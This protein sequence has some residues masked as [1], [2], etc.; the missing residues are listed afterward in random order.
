MA[1]KVLSI[2]IG[3]DCTKVCEL[4]Y[5]KKY[6]NKGI[7]VY[8]SL[9][10][11]TP[12]GS[13][14]DGFIKDMNVFGEELKNR[15]KAAKIK[16]YRVVFTINSSRIANREIIIP[17]VKEKRIID[18][19]NTGASEYF[20]I[21][22]NEY[23]LSYQILEKSTA[24]SSKDNQKRLVKNEKKL[25]KKQAK[26]GK[27]ALK[28]RNKTQIIAENL[29][30]MNSI[31][32]LEA[33]RLD[34]DNTSGGRIGKEAKNQMRLTAY[35]AP[36]AMVRNYYSFAKQ[37]N[38]DI[39]AIDYYGNSS[40][41]AIKRQGRRGINVYV[42]MNEQDTIISILRDD[43]LILQRTVSFGL[44]KLIDII[45]DFGYGQGENE[46]DPIAL[47]R[48]HDMLTRDEGN[49]PLDETAVTESFTYEGSRQILT[50]NIRES[51]YTLVG[52]VTRMLDYYKSSH[53]QIDINTIYLTGALVDIKGA[54]T[55]FGSA[56]GLHHKIMYKLNSVKASKKAPSFRSNPSKFLTLIGAVIKPVDFIP[57]EFILKKQR[58]SMVIATIFLSLVCLLGS[59]GTVYVSYTDYQIAKKELDDIS[60]EYDDMPPLSG[61]FDDYDKSVTE[62]N[63]LKLLQ[64]LTESNN[65]RIKDVI[66]ELERKL[67]SGTVTHT[68]KFTED[69]VI[70]NVT[71]NDDEAGSNALLA[72]ILKQL[73]GIDYFKDN[74][75]ISGIRIEDDNG[76]SKVN[77]TIT[78]TYVD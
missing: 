46:E 74:V 38:L 76:V 50:E 5:K 24:A 44:N 64:E 9:V 75:D 53:K 40:Y 66:E 33:N 30:K 27:K 3:S 14:E 54:E 78:C 62:L 47:L 28:K 4:K 71:A 21:D 70:M 63:D 49:M 59:I 11:D 2:L 13:V 61:A 20:P 32:E 23:I 39:L 57:Y 55:F 17:P 7:R 26:Q 8:K 58:R 29:E 35:A 19:I 52:N 67:P 1:K 41:Q 65:D 36:S 34:A 16:S 45:N 37:M 51:L 12:K 6:K 77:F 60:A 31:I 72:K 22:M 25:A 10:F 42:Q 69:K 15:L 73:K 56:I 48:N 43:I 18:I 68:M